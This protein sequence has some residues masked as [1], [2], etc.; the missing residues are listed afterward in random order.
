MHEDVFRNLGLTDGEIRI[1]VALV[2]L[3]ESGTGAISRESK[4]SKSKTY[5]ILDKLID[6]GLVGH[7]IRNGTR[8]FVANDSNT[9]LE[10]LE[11]KEESL[12][13]TKKQLEAVLP[14]LEQQRKIASKRKFAEVYEGF[15]GLKSVR[16]ELIQ[17]LKA[18]DTL[19]ILG[20]PRIANEKWEGWFLKFHRQRE[21]RGVGMK[22]IYNSNVRDYGKKRKRF[23]L[24]NVRYLPSDLV[25][26]NWIDVYN[27]AI[28]I[29]IVLKE[30]LALV[31]K[32][33]DLAN[34]FKSYFDLMWKIS[35]K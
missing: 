2:R 18:G 14:Q 10:Y 34:S 21:A 20:A 32:D 12:A 4:V 11:R 28:L 6:K 26:P 35:K 29:G 33:K 27:D 8:R 1:Y 17:T 31:I 30:P 9:I 23:K 13:R 24:T 7:I 19:L 22:I 3:G 16:E 25:S 5:E 15:Q